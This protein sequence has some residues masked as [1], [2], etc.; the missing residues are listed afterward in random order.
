M[1]GSENLLQRAPRYLNDYCQTTEVCCLSCDNR[2]HRT[3]VTKT[4]TDIV[5]K[6]GHIHGVEVFKNNYK[7]LLSSQIQ[8]FPNAVY[9]NTNTI[10]FKCF[11][12]KYSVS[13]FTH[14]STYNAYNYTYTRAVKL[15][16]S[17]RDIFSWMLKCHSNYTIS[18]IH[19]S[20]VL[21]DNSHLHYMRRQLYTLLNGQP[22]I[23]LFVVVVVFLKHFTDPTR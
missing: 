1:T 5:Q 16:L 2:T 14:I 23:R 19:K 10:T 22:I 12:Y 18:L 6:L 4:N 8:I 9:L 20:Q 21:G 3:D 17:E 11:K 7:Y 13:C 15:D